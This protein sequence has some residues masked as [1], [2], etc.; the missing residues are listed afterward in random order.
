VILILAQE[1]DRTA[2]GVVLGLAERGEPVVRLDLSWFPQRLM[3][4]AEFR[5]GAWR[6]CLRTEHHEI[7]LAAIRSVWVRSPTSFRLPEGLS[8][9][10]ADYSRREAKLGLGGVLF[11]LPGVLWVNRPD[12]AA[13]AVYK[14][15]Q[16]SVAARAGLRVPPTLVTN[17]AAALWRFAGSVA[18]VVQKP[19]STNLIFEDGGYKMG[20]THLVTDAD[21]ADLRGVATTAHHLQEW[22]PKATECRAVVVGDDIFCVA[23]HAGSDKAYVDYRADFGANTYEQIELPERVLKGLR[24]FMTELGLVY[25]AFDLVIGP[26]REGDHGGDQ[27][28]S[29][30][31]CNPGGQYQFL[32]ATAGVGI[33]DSLMTLLARGNIS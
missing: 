3:L 11:A 25:G 7:D 16:Y 5:D 13:R 10:E 9:V 27:V 19:L 12:L 33:T 6:G 23:I 21:L 18:G 8:A 31:E 1:S 24:L 2:D 20:Y 32:E 29:F 15:L 22:A 30:L 14:P 28:V 17:S 26:T 4:D